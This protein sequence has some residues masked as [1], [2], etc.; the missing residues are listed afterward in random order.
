MNLDQVITTITNHPLFL[1]LHNVIEQ[2]EGWHDHE[3]TFDHSVKTANI[4]KKAREAEFISDLE[5]KS[6]FLHFMNEDVSGVLRKDIIVLVGLLH[7]CGKIL[8]FKDGDHTQTMRQI[9][10][11][12]PSDRTMFPGHEY[13]GGALVV[14]EI[15]KSI[16]LP[17][18]VKDYIAKI[19]KLHGVFNEPPYFKSKSTWTLHQLV[20]D[21]KS[22]ADGLYIE[23][24]FNSYCDCYDASAFAESKEAI[25]EIFNAPALYTKREY[26]LPHE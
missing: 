4:A 10:P 14:P 8:S 21:V 3:P 22:R 25:E 19:V 13:Y 6:S 11:D 16:D 5:A 1:R 15:L 2:A 12:G 17:Q 20:S 26:F 23:A 7:D 24:L 18:D 9:H